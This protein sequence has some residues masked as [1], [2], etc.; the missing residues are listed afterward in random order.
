[1]FGERE[2]QQTHA[3]V[4]AATGG[5]KGGAKAAERGLRLDKFIEKRSETKNSLAKRRR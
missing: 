5:L 1:M 2:R 4:R 3:A